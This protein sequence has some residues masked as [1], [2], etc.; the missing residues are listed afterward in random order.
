[1]AL[2]DP[3]NKFLR[4]PNELF[5]AI[6]SRLSNRDIKQ[7]RLTCGLVRERAQLRLTRV[8]VSASPRNIKVLYCIA[9]HPDFCKQVTEIIWDDAT[10]AK[11]WQEGEYED[12]E[13]RDWDEE[14]GCP[15]WFTRAC[16]YELQALKTR[17]H[18]DVDRPDH[19]ARQKQIDA[20]LPLSTSW[21]FYQK[22]LDEQD[23]II[24]S[25]SDVGAFR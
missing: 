5:A 2:T 23:Q 6:L 13:S 9:N 20:S 25:G 1:M 17:K 24:S 19:I 15:M 3:P 10:L 7:L 16:H 22:L 14:N 21:V 11:F 12:E 18:R 4:L 8:F